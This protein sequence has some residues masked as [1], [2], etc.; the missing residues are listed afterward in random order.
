MG[1]CTPKGVFLEVKV[2]QGAEWSSLSFFL[3]EFSFN[4][5]LML[6]FTSVRELFL[7]YSLN[8]SNKFQW[9]K[10]PFMII[11]N[12]ASNVIYLPVSFK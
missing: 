2:H 10:A 4:N 11:T 6:P 5:L 7:T 8:L 12:E 9:D 1:T 3:A